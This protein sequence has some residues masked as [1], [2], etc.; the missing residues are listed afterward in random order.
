MREELLARPTPLL[1][2]RG[3]LL[4]L[5]SMRPSG[6]PDDRALS[7]FPALPRGVSASFAGAAGAAI[8]AAGWARTHAVSLFVALH[9]VATHETRETLR[10]FGAQVELCSSAAEALARAAARRDTVLPA[11][12]GDAA[13][14][15]IERT[16]GPELVRD[17]GDVRAV[18][19]P[20]GAR[21]ALVAALRALPGSRGIAL[22][23]ADDELP[24]LPR[25]VDLPGS[26]ER[27][28]VPRALCARARTGLARETG[29]L[30]SHASAAAAFLA[31][32]EGG[33]A[34]I[35]SGERE[36]SLEALA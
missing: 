1:R 2:F 11:L 17:A 16:L 7:L 12:D 20:A 26:V 25:E 29:V 31:A 35:S 23:A 24:G 33:L 18:I 3:A 19:A 8:A 9:G 10:L 22:V 32:A 36:F 5:E 13:A 6:E 14:S 34:L 4:K 30:A 28:P 27:R 21:A 15:A